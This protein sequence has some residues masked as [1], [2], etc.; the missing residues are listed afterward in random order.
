MLGTNVSFASWVSAMWEFCDGL[1]HSKGVSSLSFSGTF[2]T[3]AILFV[4]GLPGRGEEVVVSASG[5]DLGVGMSRGVVDLG[6]A[7]ESVM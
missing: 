7:I 1:T 5:I 3:V 4:G 2:P 6:A